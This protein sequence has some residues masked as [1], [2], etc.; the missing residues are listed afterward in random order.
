MKTSVNILMNVAALAL[1]IMSFK[2]LLLV[3]DKQ[4]T[5]SEAKFMQGIENDE[6]EASIEPVVV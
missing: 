2:L 4:V 6:R 5:A 1:V 3:V